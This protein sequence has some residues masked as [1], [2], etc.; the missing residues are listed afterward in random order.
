MSPYRTPAPPTPVRPRRRPVPT[1]IPSPTEAQKIT[2]GWL[3][4][5]AGERR[6]LEQAER[7]RNQLRAAAIA[8]WS[9]LYTSR[10]SEERREVL[11]GTKWVLDV[12][13]EIPR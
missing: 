1:T 2:N 7:E 9:V 13:A 5:W 4:E 6:E 11:E 3:L 12:N 8:L 10:L